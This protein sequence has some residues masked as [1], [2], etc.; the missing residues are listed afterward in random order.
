MPILTKL[1][2]GL[3]LESFEIQNNQNLIVANNFA[4]DGISRL[5]HGYFDFTTVHFSAK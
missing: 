1:M 2:S 4:T 3:S 5:N